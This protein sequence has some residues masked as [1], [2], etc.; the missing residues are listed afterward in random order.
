MSCAHIFDW[1][2]QS[3]NHQEAALQRFPK[4]AE[5]AQYAQGKADFVDLIAQL[6]ED[7]KAQFHGEQKEWYAAFGQPWDEVGCLP[8]TVVGE[9]TRQ[10]ESIGALGFVAAWK[11]DVAAVQAA[12]AAR[13]YK[14][15]PTG[16]W[17]PQ[18]CAVC[19]KFKRERLQDYSSQLTWDFFAD[20]GFSKDSSYDMADQFKDAC[21]SWYDEQIAPMRADLTGV[22][23]A[24]YNFG[25]NPGSTNGIMDTKTLTALKAFQHFKTG[26]S[27][28]V[29]SADTFSALG[30]NIEYAV[31]LAE[32]YGAM[33]AAAAGDPGAFINIPPVRTVSDSVT[34]ADPLEAAAI[35]EA[36]AAAT[37]RPKFSVV[38]IVVLGVGLIG[39]AL[40]LAGGKKRTK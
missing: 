21:V 12:L 8:E 10:G 39:A 6:N 1:I 18:T 20:L 25:F 2:V 33:G 29:I 27:S 3:T 4:A 5:L 14:I 9:N 31:I 13:G 16:H 28:D 17:S 22:Q 35:Q 34:V 7:E 26:S 19:Y 24:L 32:K 40:Y 23:Q 11:K 37:A 30:F 38:P 15:L 36:N